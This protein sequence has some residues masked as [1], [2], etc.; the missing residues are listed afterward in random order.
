MNIHDELTEIFRDTF[1]EPDLE[2]TD[3]TD[4]EDIAMWDSTTHIVLIFAI[5][6]RFGFKF[7]AAELEGL[8]NVGDLKASIAH[9]VQAA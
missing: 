3:E 6:D 7:S 9:H 1:A 5:E 2:L 4:A 8:A